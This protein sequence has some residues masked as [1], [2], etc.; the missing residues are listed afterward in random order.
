MQVLLCVVYS[1]AGASCQVDDWRSTLSRY[2]DRMDA[3]WVLQVALHL[4]VFSGMALAWVG[5][6]LA[7]VLN[8]A[9]LPC[10]CCC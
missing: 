9:N 2:R 3:V 8:V 1:N 6:T 10:C 4:A 7:A 5:S